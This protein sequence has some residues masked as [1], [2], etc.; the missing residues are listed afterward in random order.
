MLVLV[1]YDPRQPPY[2]PSSSYIEYAKV[3][4]QAR[5]QGQYFT[6]RGFCYAQRTREGVS[7]HNQSMCEVILERGRKLEQNP[8]NLKTPNPSLPLIKGSDRG[9]W[10]GA[11]DAGGVPAGAA[12]TRVRL[13]RR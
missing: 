9:L 11:E 13:S 7:R 10:G 3:L 2:D 1:H 12:Q 5:L 4:A 8:E 6:M